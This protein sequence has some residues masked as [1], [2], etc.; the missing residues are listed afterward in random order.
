MSPVYL[1]WPWYATAWPPTTRYSICRELSNSINSLKSLCSF[2]D[3]LPIRRNE[4]KQDLQ[5][6]LLTQR[7]VVVAVRTISLFEASEY[8]ELVGAH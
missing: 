7:R 1:G 8:P 2:T 4:I 3:R 5:T 6:L